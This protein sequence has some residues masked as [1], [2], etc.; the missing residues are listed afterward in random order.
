MEM[1]TYFVLIIICV[2]FVYIWKTR[3]YTGS[4]SHGKPLPE[5]PGLLLVG[6]SFALSM[7]TFHFKCAEFAE[8]CGK[9]FQLRMFGKRI[10][11]INDHKLLRKAFASEEYGDTFSDRPKNFTVQF[12]NKG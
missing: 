6:H 5:P 9:V 12:L 7:E 3:D 8:S 1:A 11:V 4:V 10:V 2:I